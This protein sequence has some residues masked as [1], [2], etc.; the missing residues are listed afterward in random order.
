LEESDRST[1]HP[2]RNPSTTTHTPSPK[3][4][5]AD[6]TAPDSRQAIDQ[7]SIP[8]QYECKWTGT[9]AR[10]NWKQQQWLLKIICLDT[11]EKRMIT[12]SE[13]SVS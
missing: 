5:Y 12:S 10:K 13:L 7:E 11:A 4:F 1:Q 6:Y 3:A 8:K 2:T 9:F